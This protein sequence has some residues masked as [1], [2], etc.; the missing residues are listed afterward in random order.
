VLVRSSSVF[1]ADPCGRVTSG[2]RLRRYRPL[3]T[4]GF[5]RCRARLPW[6]QIYGPA[7][8]PMP[9]V[10]APPKPQHLFGVDVA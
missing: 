6:W 4:P 7:G 8:E 5:Q 1:T 10:T 2:V 3:L 9:A